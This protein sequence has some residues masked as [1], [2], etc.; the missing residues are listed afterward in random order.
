MTEPRAFSLADPSTWP[1]RMVRAE[2]AAVL[3]IS[4]RELRRRIVAG[5]FPAADDGRTWERDVVDR[6]VRGGIKSF[7]RAKDHSRRFFS[8]AGGR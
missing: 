3:R 5:R 2:V 7:E 6:Y 1:M 8:M 4:Q